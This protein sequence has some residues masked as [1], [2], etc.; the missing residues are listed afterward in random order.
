M[1]GGDPNPDAS[2]SILGNHPASFTPDYSK[3][4][5]KSAGDVASAEFKAK[6]DAINAKAAEKAAEAA[7]VEAEQ[8]ANSERKVHEDIAELKKAEPK[9]LHEKE[10]NAEKLKKLEDKAAANQEAHTKEAVAGAV[11]VKADADVTL[12][13]TKNKK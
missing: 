4:T 1:E 9:T 6:G 7:K 13:K 11:S 10:A 8:R 12:L 5:T 3:S 2:R